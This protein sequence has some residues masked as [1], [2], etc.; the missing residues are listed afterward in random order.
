MGSWEQSP[1][2]FFMSYNAACNYFMMTLISHSFIKV[3][4]T[5]FSDFFFILVDFLALTRGGGVEG[6]KRE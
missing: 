5:I 1:F 3:T 6:L 2:S 4:S